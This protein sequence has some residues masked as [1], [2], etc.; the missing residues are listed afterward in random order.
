MEN[1]DLTRRLRALAAR[2]LDAYEAIELPTTFAEADRAARA[3]ISIGKA[4]ALAG[5]EAPVVKSEPQP[6]KASGGSPYLEIERQAR[7]LMETDKALRGGQL[8]DAEIDALLG[9]PEPDIRR[10]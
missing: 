10:F 6:R 1:T 9:P 7:A 3:L 4:I 8:S 5:D 2:L